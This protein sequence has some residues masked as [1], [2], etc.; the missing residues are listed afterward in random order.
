MTAEFMPQDAACPECDEP[1]PFTFS[2]TSGLGGWKRGEGV[3][4]TPDVAHYVCFFCAKAWKRRLSGPLT[5]DV[6]GDLAFFS[7]RDLDCGA[8]LTISHESAVPTEVELTCQQG[9]RYGVAWTED[10]GLTLALAS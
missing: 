5:P 8:R 10:G 1:M 3:N 2:E 7:C 4:T 6:V 9:H